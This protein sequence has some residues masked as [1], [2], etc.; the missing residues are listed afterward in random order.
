MIGFSGGADFSTQ[1]N[2]RV[3]E[4]SPVFLGDQFHQF[5]FDFDGVFGIV[6]RSDQPQPQGDPA[7]MGIDGDAFVYPAGRAENDVGGFPGDTGKCDKVLHCLGNL[8]V[9]FF[10]DG[11]TGTD[12]GFCFLAEKACRTDVLLQFGFVGGGEIA[13][14]AIFF[15]KVFG[16][17]VDALVGALGGENRCD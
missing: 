1:K 7:D 3:A 12:D 6:G 14:G 16:D 13:G 2:N 9:E 11:F 8:A 17:D 10:A 5:F 15:E 4:I